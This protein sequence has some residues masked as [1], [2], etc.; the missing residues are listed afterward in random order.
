MFNMNSGYNG[1]S[2]SNRA[3]EAYA[4]GERPL[5]KWT[6]TDILSDLKKLGVDDGMIKELKKLS[7]QSLA[8]A[9][10]YCSSWHH[11][12][13]YCLKT[14]FYSVD[15]L[16]AKNITQEYIDSIK[17]LEEMLKADTP[18]KRSESAA[19]DDS[20]KADVEY[21]EWSGTRKHP[22]ATKVE[23]KNC[24]VKEKGCF[25]LITTSTGESLK[26]KIG[27]NGTKVIRI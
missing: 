2:M 22:K 19:E 23:L 1:F 24:T 27:S 16:K 20:Y 11:T 5:S 7:K 17:K 26:K 12:S 9:F 6:K 3:V 8:N 25:Y 13:S 4:N 18:A 14:N 10:L 21:L 15:E